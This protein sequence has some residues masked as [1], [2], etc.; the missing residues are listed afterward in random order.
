[1][2]ERERLESPTHV[3]S[4]YVLL[5]RINLMAPSDTMGVK[6]YWVRCVWKRNRTRYWSNFHHTLQ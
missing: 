1:M 4:A 5:G 6:E 3:T 2:K